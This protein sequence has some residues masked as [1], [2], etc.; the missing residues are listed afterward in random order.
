[1]FSMMMKAPGI[2]LFQKDSFLARDSIPSPSCLER[3]GNFHSRKTPL[4]RYGNWIAT[5]GNSHL[6]FSVC[7]TKCRSTSLTAPQSPQTISF[8]STFP[9]GNRFLTSRPRPA[10]PL[11]VPKRPPVA[12]ASLSQSL[13]VFPE[14]AAALTLALPPVAVVA[15]GVNGQDVAA[16]AFTLAASLVWVGLFNELARREVIEQVW[17]GLHSPRHSPLC[18][19]LSVASKE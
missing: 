9:G 2:V 5:A 18:Q 8:G 3:K 11:T 15:S 13:G 12:T 6:P 19:R 4:L 17:H 14:A 16:G 7:Y 1:M 10:S